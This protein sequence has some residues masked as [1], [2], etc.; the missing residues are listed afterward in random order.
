MGYNTRCNSALKT[1]GA[2]CA[3]DFPLWLTLEA[4][5]GVDEGVDASWCSAPLSLSGLRRGAA[6]LMG[7]AP[8][9]YSNPRHQSA[10]AAC[11]WALR[12][13]GSAHAQQEKWPGLP[14]Q[15]ALREQHSK[16]PKEAAW[17]AA[18]VH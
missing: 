7:D 1:G 15:G 5:P 18:H 8:C 3:C 6:A 11:G 13:P 10:Y 14:L 12:K 4:S 16:H 17:A 9:H 2:Y